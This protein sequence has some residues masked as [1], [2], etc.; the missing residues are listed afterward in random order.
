M[1]T[2]QPREPRTLN[3]RRAWFVYEGARIAAMAA[4]APIVPEPWEQRDEAW[5]H[6]FVIGQHRY[7]S[8][9]R[10]GSQTDG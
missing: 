2:E 9:D 1:T 5:F 3:E 6:W 4:L 8:L 7:G 10:T